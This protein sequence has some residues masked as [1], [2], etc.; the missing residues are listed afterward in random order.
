MS[1]EFE[2]DASLIDHKSLLKLQ[3]GG[4]APF[5]V[6]LFLLVLGAVAAP[7][8]RSPELD[9]FLVMCQPVGGRGSEVRG[10]NRE[11]P[12]FREEKT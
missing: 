10:Q 2:P 12:G 3:L 1:P 6:V 7:D 5:H 8:L 9:G 11:R 4:R